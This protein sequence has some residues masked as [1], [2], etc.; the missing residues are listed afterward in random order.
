[1]QVGVFFLRAK[2]PFNHKQPT[3]QCRFDRER[4]RIIFKVGLGYQQNAVFI[5]FVMRCDQNKHFQT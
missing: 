2:M 5:V 1:M 4:L 3:S